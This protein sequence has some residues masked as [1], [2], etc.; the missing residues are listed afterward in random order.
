MTLELDCSSSSKNLILSDQQS[1]PDRADVVIVGAGLAGILAA[2]TL[3]K[4]GFQVQLI[5]RADFPRSKVCGCCLNPFALSILNQAN[6][7]SLPSKLGGIPLDSLQL[8]SRGVSARLSLPGW[9][10]VSRLQLDSALLQQAIEAGIVFRPGIQARLGP[11]TNHL[12]RIELGDGTQVAAGLIL[13]A[14]GL[15]GGFLARHQTSQIATGSHVGIGVIVNNGSEF[16][17]PGTVYMAHGPHG[18]LG[19]VRLEDHRLNLAAAVNP[20]FLKRCGHPGIFAQEL[21]QSVGWPA[22]EGLSH[23]KWRGTPA[24]TR[25]TP[26]LGAE[27]VLAIG[28]AAGY[29]EPFTGEGMAWALASGLAVSDFVPEALENWDPQIISRWTDQYNSIVRNRQWICRGLSWML[30]RP[31]LTWGVIS[32]LHRFPGL[33]QP[34][35]WQIGAPTKH[36]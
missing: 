12:R 32:L 28:D 7:G 3:Q 11:V 4:K 14:D 26:L 30:R 36:P 25:S 27:R 2:I 33:A 15:G 9:I 6:L 24:L 10:A 22:L 21:L 19:L 5:D 17:S 29:V 23:I 13:A 18:Y 35:V 34:W 1:I 31:S 16:Y 8:A 20:H